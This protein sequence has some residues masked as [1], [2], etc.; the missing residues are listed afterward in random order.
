MP[1]TSLVGQI[2]IQGEKGVQERQKKGN[3]KHKDSLEQQGEDF[4]ESVKCKNYKFEGEWK[5][6]KVKC[7]NCQKFGHYAKEC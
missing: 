3:K 6:K 2:S 7:Y 1:R 5:F 4:S